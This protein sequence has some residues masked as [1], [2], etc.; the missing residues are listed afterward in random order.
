MYSQYGNWSANRSGNRSYRSTL[1]GESYTALWS[2][3][4]TTTPGDS[5]PNDV[6]SA[7]IRELGVSQPR[8]LAALAAIQL[9]CL[10]NA[11][12]IRA[13]SVPAPQRWLELLGS[14]DADILIY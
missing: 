11:K 3:N 5:T 14:A 10:T 4:Q 13:A 8:S 1:A 12:I 6:I 7:K 9:V 2:L